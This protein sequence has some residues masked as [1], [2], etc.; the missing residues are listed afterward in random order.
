MEIQETGNGVLISFRVNPHSGGFGF[1]ERSGRLVLDLKSRP[2]RGMANAE[3]VSGLGRLF[4]RD[5]EIV[6]GRR[7]RD[8]AVLVR[9]IPL[10]EARRILEAEKGQHPRPEQA[11]CIS[12]QEELEEPPHH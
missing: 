8:K 12:E 7:S 11:S 3:I 10:Q 2:E 6:R 9:N 1:T 4:G 5:V